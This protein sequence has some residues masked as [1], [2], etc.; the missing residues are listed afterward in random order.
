MGRGDHSHRI[1]GRTATVVRFASDE[2]GNTALLLMG[3][4]YVML[5]TIWYHSFNFKNVKNTHEGDIFLVKLQA[6]TCNFTKIITL[7]FTSHFLNCTDGTKSRKA[8]YM[9]HLKCEVINP[10]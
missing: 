7:S 9:I 3:N 8:S 6:S 2:V 1:G 5:C 10:P 4:I